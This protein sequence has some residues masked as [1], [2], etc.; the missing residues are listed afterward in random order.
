[1]YIYI[2]ILQRRENCKKL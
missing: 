2:L 1:M